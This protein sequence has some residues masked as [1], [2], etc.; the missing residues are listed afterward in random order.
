MD[1][2]SGC[3]AGGQQLSVVLCDNT[4]GIRSSGKAIHR[5]SVTGMSSVLHRR[6][7]SCLTNYSS[8]VY[9][10]LPGIYTRP[11]LLSRFKLSGVTDVRQSAVRLVHRQVT[12]LEMNVLILIRNINAT[13]KVSFSFKLGFCFYRN[14]HIESWWCWSLNW[15]WFNQRILLCISFK[16]N[17]WLSKERRG[18]KKSN[19]YN[20]NW[21]EWAISKCE[22]PPRS[23]FGAFWPNW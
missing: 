6:P 18:K 1:G 17:I 21:Y 5:W 12:V 22:N 8:R 15:R 11:S 14:D 13:P 3:S 23:V 19:P 9:F 4:S 10:G 7:C 2:W 16:R 20:N